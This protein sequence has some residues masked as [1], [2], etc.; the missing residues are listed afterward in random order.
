MST[1]QR[2]L[3]VLLVAVILGYGVYWFFDNFEKVEQQIHVGLRGEAARNPLLAAE[4][5]L[6]RLELKTASRE[7]LLGLSDLPPVPGALITTGD[8]LTLSEAEHERLLDWVSGGGHLIAKVRDGP[9][10]E[11]EGASAG[12]PGDEPSAVPPRGLSDPFL[13]TAGYGLQIP[14]PDWGDGDHPAIDLSLPGGPTLLVDLERDR[15]ITGARPGDIALGSALGDHLVSRPYG[16]G[17]LTLL[18]DI[19]LFGNDRIGDHDH[20]ALLAWLTQLHTSPQVVWLVH[21]D[22]MV[23][24]GGWLWTHARAVVIT[25]AAIIAL[26][27]AGRAQR[28]G[29]ILGMPPPD[30]RRITEHIQAAGEFYWRHGQGSDLLAEA[31]GELQHRLARR[32]PEL[33]HAGDAERI[34]RI[35]ELCGLPVAIVREA[36]EAAPARDPDRYT[37]Q[38]QGLQLIGT[39]L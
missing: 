30:R 29:P 3:I 18:T 15:V 10:A 13:Q 17:R 24:L 6:S 14:D 35:A 9:R 27:L 5:F 11:A 2:T 36:L 21:G 34:A 28:F 20:A 16:D 8:R 33:R 12:D 4:R 32:Y 23:G 1:G 19:D 39:R 31:R 37:T 22:D 26:W 25:F 7:S 38:A